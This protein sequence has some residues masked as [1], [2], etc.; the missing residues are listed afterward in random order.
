MFFTFRIIVAVAHRMH[1]II[2]SGN[3]FWNIF[4]RFGFQKIH[5]LHFNLGIIN[6]HTFGKTVFIPAT[7]NDLITLCS[8]YIYHSFSD[9]SGSSGKKNFFHKLGFG[10]WKLL[11]LMR[12]IIPFLKDARNNL[13]FLKD[14]F[15]SRHSI[16]FPTELCD[17]E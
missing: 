7:A 8:D 15:H 9:V 2:R 6:I 3:I 14:N 17:A 13:S 1:Q 16:L 11:Q 10:K 4:Q 12:K 5:F